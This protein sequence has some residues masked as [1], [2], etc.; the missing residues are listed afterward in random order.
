MY[1]E[2][3]INLHLEKW[4]FKIHPGEWLCYK[5][6]SWYVVNLS[7][8]R[9]YSCVIS[10]NIFALIINE[11]FIIFLNILEGISISIKIIEQLCDNGENEIMW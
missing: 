8:L 7:H 6:I 2:G 5:F 9:W 3:A 11:Y 4:M 10:I 1:F